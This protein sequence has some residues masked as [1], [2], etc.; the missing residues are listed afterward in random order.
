M[1]R[2]NGQATNS[3][4]ERER[5]ELQACRWHEEKKQQFAESG[6]TIYACSPD[7]SDRVDRRRVPTR[8]RKWRKLCTNPAK[9][10]VCFL[11]DKTKRLPQGE[12][13]KG[14]DSL[15]K[16]I[17]ERGCRMLSCVAWPVRLPIR[18]AWNWSMKKRVPDPMPSL[19]AQPRTR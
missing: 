14:Q 13:T 11:W 9:N 10:H 16:L 19:E 8:R 4:T 2:H 12:E 15:A 1:L 18:L 7:I 17:S 5:Q 3:L 6:T